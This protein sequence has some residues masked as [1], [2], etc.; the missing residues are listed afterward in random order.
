MNKKNLLGKFF[1]F[2]LLATVVM[3]TSSCN[4]GYGCPYNTSV[5]NVVKVINFSIFE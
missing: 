3:G 5:S 4:R 1:A 2:I